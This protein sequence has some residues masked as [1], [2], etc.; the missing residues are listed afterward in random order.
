MKAGRRGSA[1]IEASIALPLLVLL[2]LGVVDFGF[3]IFDWITVVNAA[4][5]AAEYQILGS[6]SVGI[7]VTTPGYP[8]VF[9]NFQNDVSSLPNYM[10]NASLEICTFSPSNGSSSSS[11]LGSGPTIPTVADPNYTFYG[12]AVQYAFTPVI[13]V[14]FLQAQNISQ[15]VYMRSLN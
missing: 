2:L 4:R 14:P 7:N 11:C 9:G 12:I 15:I 5:N 8:Q 13:P 1:L 10:T 3:Y 6:K